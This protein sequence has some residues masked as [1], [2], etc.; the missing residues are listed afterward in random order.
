MLDD[1]R[2]DGVFVCWLAAVWWGGLGDEGFQDGVL[3]VNVRGM[4]HGNNS[5]SS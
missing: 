3:E 5:R 2:V 4:I 1:G